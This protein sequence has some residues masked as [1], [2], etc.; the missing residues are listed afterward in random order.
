MNLQPISMNL[1]A[2]LQPHA[3]AATILATHVNLQQTATKLLAII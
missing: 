3:A 1:S 2:Y